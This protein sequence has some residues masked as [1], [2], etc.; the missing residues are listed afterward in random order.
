[1]DSDDKKIT[2]LPQVTTLSDSDLFVVSIDVGTAPKTRAIKKSDVIAG[3][4]GADVLQVQVF[5]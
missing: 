2:Q 3:G 1:M 4:G 5:S